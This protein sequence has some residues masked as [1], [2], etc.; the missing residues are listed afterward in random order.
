MYKVIMEFTVHWEHIHRIE[1]DETACKYRFITLDGTSDYDEATGNTS[2]RY[3]FL[4]KIEECNLERLLKRA[5]KS[6]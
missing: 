3:D 5:A 1:Y 6:N 4:E 2:I